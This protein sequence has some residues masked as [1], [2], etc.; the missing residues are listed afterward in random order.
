[1]TVQS[2]VRKVIV[3][4]ILLPLAISMVLDAQD[5]STDSSAYRDLVAKAKGG[6]A[7]VDYRQ[8]RFL[9]LRL[10]DCRLRSTPDQLGRLHALKDPKEILAYADTL[11]AEGFVNLE[12][13]ADEVALYQALGDTPRAARSLGIVTGLLNSIMK[14]RDGKSPES[15]Y[16]VVV[17]REIYIVQATRGLPSGYG[18]GVT[19]EPVNAGGRKYTR[20]SIKDP[21]SGETVIVYFDVTA[22]VTKSVGAV[23]PGPR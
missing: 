12:V 13:H 17:D 18:P 7:T 9:C 4:S 3:R 22:F 20:Y 21:R 16:E 14:G 11:L 19:S 23:P 15:A 8:M 6:D 5:T 10:P 2:I 1:M